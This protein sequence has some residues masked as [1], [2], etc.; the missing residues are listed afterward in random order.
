MTAHL[1]RRVTAAAL[2][3]IAI[4]FSMVATSMSASTASAAPGPAINA[5]APGLI[6][7]DNLDGRR[8]NLTVR[9]RSMNRNIQVQVIRP[10]NTSVPR[11]VLYLLNG[12]GGGEDSATWEAQTDVFEFFEHKNVNVVTPVGGA[13]SYY[14]DWLRRDPVL[15]LNKWTTFLTKELPP[16]V[17]A[18]LRTSGKNAIAG[19]SMSGSA[20]MSLAQHSPKLYRAVGAY[21]GCAQTATEPGRAYVNMVVESRGGGSSNNM[22]GPPGSRAWAANDAYINAAKLRGISL[23]ISSASGLPGKHDSLASPDLAGDPISL[24]NQVALGGIIEA[25]VDQCTR[26]LQGRLASLRIPATFNFKPAGTHSWLYWQDDL[27]RSWPQLARA[28]GTR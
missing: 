24:A 18:A 2:P 17:N 1:F 13:F 10:A 4:A 19:I 8:A 3:A 6:S 9:S 16:I 20:V 28:I 23:Y 21:S 5:A 7:V 26:A 25:A 11:P 12:A 15:G 14:T 22:W 27:H